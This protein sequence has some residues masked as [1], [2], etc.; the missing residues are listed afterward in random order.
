MD[1]VGIS[2]N[3][4]GV[5]FQNNTGKVISQLITLVVAVRLFSFFGDENLT[6]NTEIEPTINVEISIMLDW[7]YIIPEINHSQIMSNLYVSA[8]LKG[9]CYNQTLP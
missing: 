8:D 6:S 3:N 2:L 7:I 9:N 5:Y 4:L 1:E